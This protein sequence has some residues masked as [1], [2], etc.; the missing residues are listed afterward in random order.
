MKCIESLRKVRGF[1]L[2]ELMMVVAIIGILAVLAL[3][4]YVAY[5]DEARFSEA[6]LAVGGVKA[7]VAVNVQNG[8]IQTLS[9]MNSGTNG[10]P[11]EQ[12]R[13]ATQHGIEVEDGVIAVTWRNDGS[14]L[15]GVAV[16]LTALNITP[17][18]RW[19]IGGPCVTRDIC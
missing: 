18:I 2:I 13:T 17:P 15:D 10:I 14:R 11:I 8:R 9:D 4:S 6:I 19:E 12:E 7:S 16:H 5:S 3:P 1:T